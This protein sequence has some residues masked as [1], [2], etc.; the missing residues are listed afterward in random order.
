MKNGPLR[1]ALV[2]KRKNVLVLQLS[3][4]FL[5]Y[6]KETSKAHCLNN[7]AA[8]VWKLCDG[9]RTV[10]QII[11]IL[12]DTYPDAASDIRVDVADTIDDLMLTGAVKMVDPH[13]PPAV[14]VG[15]GT[16]STRPE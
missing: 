8:E 16:D 1:S 6:D 4:E 14:P 7:T 5:V 3:D 15:R 9:T 2:P 12:V 10:Q 13:D 11:D